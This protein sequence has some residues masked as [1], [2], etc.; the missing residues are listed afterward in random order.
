MDATGLE[1]GQEVDIYVQHAGSPV[2]TKEGLTIDAGALC[3]N[4]ISS[5]EENKVTVQENAEGNLFVEIWTCAA[6]TFTIFHGGSAGDVSIVSPISGGITNTETPT[7]I[8]TG[9]TS[10]MVVTLTGNTGVL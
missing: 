7:I 2:Y 6:S 8:G 4:G 1:S 3:E 9:N 10:G 5:N